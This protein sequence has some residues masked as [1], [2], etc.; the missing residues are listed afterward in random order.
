MEVIIDHPIG[1]KTELIFHLRVNTHTA[2]VHEEEAQTD[3]ELYMTADGKNDFS[4]DIQ[5]SERFSHTSVCVCVWRLLAHL[6]RKA[7]T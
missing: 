3:G 1:W 6:Y 5:T 7:S 2:S 4:L